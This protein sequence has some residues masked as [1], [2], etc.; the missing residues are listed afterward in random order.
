MLVRVF[1]S[2]VGILILAQ[3]SV[4]SAEMTIEIIGAGEIPGSGRDRAIRR[5]RQSWRKPLG[6]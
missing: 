5:R 3:A 6:M 2:V 4:A 1:R